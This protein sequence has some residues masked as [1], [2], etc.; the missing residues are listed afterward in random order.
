MGAG[1]L[2]QLKRLNE[3]LTL[4]QKLSIAALGTV[5]LFGLL[6]FAYLVQKEPYQLLFSDLDASNASKVI[7]RLEQLQVPYQIADGGRSIL[8]P[9]ERIDEVRLQLAGERLPSVGRLGLE[10]FDQ[11]NWG[12]TDFAQ[13]VNYRRALEGELERTILTLNEVERARVHLVMPKDALFA[14]DRQPAKASVVLRLAGPGTL[15]RGK[16]RA[17]QNLVAFAV[18]GLDPKNVTVVDVNGNLLSSDAFSEESLNAVQ[19]SLQRKVERE[20]CQK[21]AAI[22]APIVGEDSVQVSASV[23]LDF[24]ERRETQQQVTDPVVISQQVSR[25]DVTGPTSGGVPFRSNDP[26]AAGTGA[27]GAVP[28]GNGSGAG[29]TLESQTTNY[30]VSRTVRET[31]MPSGSILRQSVAVVVNH[32]PVENE[33]GEIVFEPRDPEEMERIR[34]LVSATIGFNPDRGDILTVEN[35]PF[36]GLPEEPQVPP[37]TFLE[38]HRDTIFV[39]GRY[40]LVLLLFLLFYLM[41]FRPVKNRVFSYVEVER[42]PAAS[43]AGAIQDP[44]LLKQLEQAMAEGKLLPPGAEGEKESPYRKDIVKLAKEDPQA[45]V[46]LIRSWLSE[47]A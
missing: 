16:V 39:V 25:E 14:E 10:L 46:N 5:I 33:E 47:G 28:S 40:F 38:Q 7:E 35:V 11:N 8:V 34:K 36:S 26:A 31:V 20:L 9:A 30:E 13:K 37:P 29:R 42:T 43:L 17:I 45:L 22:L 24:S 1:F 6:F 12:V 32:R 3:S 19:V 4:N 41:I 15:D 21:V 2:A 18:E 27:A 23:Q 44:E